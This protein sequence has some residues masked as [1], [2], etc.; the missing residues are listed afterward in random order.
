[1]RARPCQTAPDKG[2]PYHHPQRNWLK[3]LFYTDTL[4]YRFGIHD[5]F[6]IRKPTCWCI[7]TAINSLH[8]HQL[9]EFVCWR[10]T[11]SVLMLEH[12]K[13]A[14]RHFASRCGSIVLEQIGQCTPQQCKIILRETS[15]LGQLCR[16]K[17]MHPIE[18]IRHDMFAP[19]RSFFFQIL[20]VRN[21]HTR[22]GNFHRHNWIDRAG[23]CELNWAAHLP[24]ID[25]CRHYCAERTHIEKVFTHPCG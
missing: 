18:S 1:G 13:F 23:E 6:V 11:H 16:N 22:D 7:C 8:I 12:N 20:F 14:R 24:G 3:K 4:R 25:F 21:C 19:H 5:Y 10:I 15:T 9:K 17:S 2:M